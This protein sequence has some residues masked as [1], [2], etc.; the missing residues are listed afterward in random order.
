MLSIANGRVVA[1]HVG[2]GD[3]VRKGQLVMEVQSPDVATAFGSYLKAVAD[4]HLTQTQLTRAQLLFSKGATS[5]SQ[6]D[7]AQNGEQ[8]AKSDLT[9]AGQQLRILGVDPRHPS[10]TV[11]VY[12]PIS[13]VVISQNTTAA[14]IAGASLAGTA[15]S[16][17][18]ADLT[19]IWVVCDVFENDLSTVH[20][21]ESAQ[22]HLDAFPNQPRTGTISDIGSILDPSIRTAKV[23]IQ[24]PNPDRLLRIGMF[25]TATFRNA[26]PIS[27]VTIPANAV[28]HLHDSE[29]VF[30]PTGGDG[31]YRRTEIHTGTDPRQRQHC[32][33]HSQA[34]SDQPADRRQCAGAAERGLTN[35]PQARRSLPSTT[36]LLF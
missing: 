19:R 18:I 20:L 13:G 36:A 25:A 16:L 11:K 9:A 1:L 2:L 34:S 8:D 21:G 7:V 23:R 26:R 29:F 22:I 10:D 35:D 14:G 4:E 17:T 32:G 24:V 5:Q 31:N 6:L 30:L 28:L 15:G 3:A 33:G 12:A 27:A